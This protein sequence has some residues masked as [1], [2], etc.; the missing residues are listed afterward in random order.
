MQIGN[1]MK[2][3]LMFLVG[4]LLIEMGLHGTPGSIL[5]ALITPAYMSGGNTVQGGTN[6]TT[7]A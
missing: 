6:G 7:A 2:L 4:F 1:G 5:G 3:F